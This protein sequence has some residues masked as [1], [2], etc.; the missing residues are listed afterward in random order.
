MKLFF[1]KRITFTLIQI[2][3]KRIILIYSNY[4]PNLF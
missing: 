4:T 2:I 1:L 3:K